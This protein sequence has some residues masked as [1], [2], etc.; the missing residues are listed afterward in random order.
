[1]SDRHQHRH[2]R[3]P[4]SWASLALVGMA[5]APAVRPGPVAGRR[6]AG[7]G[8]AHAL[9][10][11]AVGVAGLPGLRRDRRSAAALYLLPR[12]RSLAWDRM[13]G[14]SAE[15]GVL[16][17]GLTLRHRLDLGPH[18]PGACTGRGTPASP[19]PPCCSCST[20]ATSPCAG[21]P[22]TPTSGPSGAPSPASSPSSTSRSCY[23]RSSGGAPCTRR[24]RSARSR[25]VQI[26][27]SMLFSL[28]VGVVAFTLVYAWLMVHRFRVARLEEQ[29]DD[30]GA[31]PRARGAPGRSGAA[32]DVV[33]RDAAC[34]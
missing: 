26:S 27:G 13:A 1:M 6:G 20:S 11:R 5:V 12:T 24:P 23:G 25:D 3:A 33:R 7:R 30:H 21:C 9:H 16:F 29:L 4:G 19:P 8:R 10:P 17:T 18:R 14:A 34:R 22:P 15:I 28:F 32:E 2:R 31:R